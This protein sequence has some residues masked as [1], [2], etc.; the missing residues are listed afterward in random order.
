[1]RPASSPEVAQ[2]EA[3]LARGEAKAAQARLRAHL[4]AHPGDARA[5]YDLG[6]AFEALDQP[7]EAMTAYRAAIRSAPDF[8]EALNNLGL[9]ALASDNADTAAALFER[10]TVADGSFAPAFV[11]LALAFERLGDLE[12]AGRAYEAA[13]ALTPQ[14]AL[15]RANFGL[16]LLERQEP[17]PA[18]AAL[19]QAWRDAPRDDPA[20]LLAIGNGLRRAGASTLAVAVMEAAVRARTEGP[21]PALLA[22]LAL[23]HVAAG[24]RTRG[25]AVLGKA[26]SL[27]ARYATGHYLLANLLAGRGAFAEAITHYDAALKAEPDAPFAEAAKKKRA[28]ARAAM[29]P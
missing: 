5:Q 15:T 25:E 4:G 14:D 27:D 12:R 9:L 11:N 21:T 8:P 3:M 10:A 29:R 16:L 23:A 6:L 22:E 28:A 1:M 18:R 26:L 2:A 17:G 20:T 7:L 19:E 24:D 13:L